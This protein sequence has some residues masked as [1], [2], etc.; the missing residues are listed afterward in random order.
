MSA[1][2]YWIVNAFNAFSWRDAVDITVIAYLIYQA[3]KLV[4]ETRAA[5][6]VKGIAMLLVL[7]V[8]ARAAELRTMKFLC[9]AR[10]CVSAGTAPRARTGWALPNRKAASVFVVSGRTGCKDRLDKVY[11]RAGRGSVRAVPSKNRRAD[12]N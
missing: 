3:I 8:I 11:Q 1:L 5:Q 9:C 10:G 6:L 4:R 12:C 7:Y 2:W